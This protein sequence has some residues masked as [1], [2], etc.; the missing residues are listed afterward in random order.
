MKGASETME[1]AAGNGAP[2]PERKEGLLSLRQRP[3]RFLLADTAHGR[4]VVRTLG[5]PGYIAAHPFPVDNPGPYARFEDHGILGVE[6][7]R[8]AEIDAVA[9][10]HQRARC[11]SKSG[12]GKSG[13]GAHGENGGEKK[14]LVYFT[15]TVVI[16]LFETEIMQPSS[17]K[18]YIHAM[19]RGINIILSYY[20]LIMAVEKYL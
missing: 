12:R 13:E 3:F 4:I 19:V 17:C 7:V 10:G 1:K 16:V 8:G 9:A 11:V 2:P 5:M 18:T 15:P 20:C 6:S 14:G